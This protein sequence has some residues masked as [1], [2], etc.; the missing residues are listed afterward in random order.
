MSSELVELLKSK[1]GKMKVQFE[2][3]APQAK[4]VQLGGT[5]NNW[6]PAKTPFKKNGEGKWKASLELPTGR[7][8]YRYLVDN[9]W[10][11]DQRPVECVPNT[12][13]SWNCV[14]VVK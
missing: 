14:L 6:D 5:F 4:Q 12:F 11:N 10:Q 2:Y 9:A 8:E 13:G 1:K 3:F 7:Y